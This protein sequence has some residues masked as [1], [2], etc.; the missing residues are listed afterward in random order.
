MEV[1]L[2]VTAIGAIGAI[3]AA[4]IGALEAIG[5]AA[6]GALAAIAAAALLQLL[7]SRPWLHR[8]RTLIVIATAVLIETFSWLI[9]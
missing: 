7:S 4:E 9:E 1:A 8:C 6:I 5:A 3:G 2:Q